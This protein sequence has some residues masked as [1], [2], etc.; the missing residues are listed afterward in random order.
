MLESLGV[1]CQLALVEKWAGAKKHIHYERPKS[2][3]T[4]M[5]EELSPWS[6]AVRCSSVIFA[7]GEIGGNH[8]PAPRECRP[9]R[10][11][12]TTVK[13]RPC[14]VASV[15]KSRK[16]IFVPALSHVV[17]QNR[18]V[19]MTSLH[20]CL[21]P[22]LRSNWFEPHCPGAMVV[23]VRNQPGSYLGT[24]PFSTGL[25]SGTEAETAGAMVLTQTPKG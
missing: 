2:L 19:G 24:G 18:G 15:K 4:W 22:L 14:G 16:A 17:D 21:E 8:Q 9:N 12:L 1:S 13:E 7:G 23:S 5:F 6:R 11:S 20:R 3:R 25:V 10:T